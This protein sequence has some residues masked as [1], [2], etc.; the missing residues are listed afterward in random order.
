MIGTGY[1][2]ARTV[3]R[4]RGHTTSRASRD[5]QMRVKHGRAEVGGAATGQRNTK[6]DGPTSIKKLLTGAH[7]ANLRLELCFALEKQSFGHTPSHDHSG[8]RA[9]LWREFSQ[10]VYDDRRNN[11]EAATLARRGGVPE[12]AS[13]DDD[14]DDDDDE[15]DA[16]PPCDPKFYRD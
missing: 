6:P 10:L 12:G 15:E 5:V 4:K 7:E 13:E 9:D 3:G 14:D 1:G 2:G 8:H 16:A 11:E